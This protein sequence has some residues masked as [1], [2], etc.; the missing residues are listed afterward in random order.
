MNAA[1]TKETK[2]TTTGYIVVAPYTPG[3]E[4]VEVSEH[5]TLAQARTEAF[6]YQDRRPDLRGQDVRILRA[7]GRKNGS[8]DCPDGRER[9]FVEY[10][11]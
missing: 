2:M 4:P 1:P 10:G 7:L 8:R 11:W 3:A 9:K 6:R 5:R